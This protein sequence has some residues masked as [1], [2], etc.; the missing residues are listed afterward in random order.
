M[1]N[2]QI[3]VGTI[4]WMN[5]L[6]EL[7][8]GFTVLDCGMATG[9]KDKGTLTYHHLTL[10]GR[11]AINASQ[12]FTKGQWV[13]ID[14]SLHVDAYTKEGETIKKTKV[15]VNK[16]ELLPENGDTCNHSLLLGRI[17]YVGDFKTESRKIQVGLATWHYYKGEK[18]TTF[19]SLQFKGDMAEVIDRHSQKGDSLLIQGS[20]MTYRFPSEKREVSNI[21]VNHFAFL[22]RRE[23]NENQSNKNDYGTNERNSKQTKQKRTQEP[24]SNQEVYRVVQGNIEVVSQ[25]LGVTIEVIQKWINQQ[26][27][28]ASRMKQLRL[29]EKRGFF[30][31]NLVA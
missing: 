10:F 19:H 7:V 15:R 20:L 2:E 28:P 11:N 13:M 8:E 6:K 25:E 5:E 4:T 18:Q 17:T 3:L 9:N 31:E 23:K 12:L 21:L 26:K 27:I 1:K 30:L 16:F 14:G 24:M 22:G 29:L